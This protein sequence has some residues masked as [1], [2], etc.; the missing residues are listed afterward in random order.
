VA[1]YSGRLFE[2]VGL[3]GDGNFDKLKGAIVKNEISWR[4][5][6][7]GKGTPCASIPQQWNVSGWP[8]IYVID[9]NGVIQEKQVYGALLQKTLARLIAFA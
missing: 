5:F 7:R 2:H 6:L 8:T 4:S 3:A 9:H 1:R